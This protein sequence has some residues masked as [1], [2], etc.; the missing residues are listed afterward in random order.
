MIGP[1]L[2][3]E[4][5][6]GGRKRRLHLLRWLCGGVLWLQPMRDAAGTVAERVRQ[7]VGLSRSL[8]EAKIF[9]P[10]LVHLVASGE[11]SGRLPSMAD[12]TTV[13][14]ATRSLRSFNLPLV[15]RETSSR[16]SMRRTIWAN[17]RSI[18]AWACSVVLRS[19]PAIRKSCSALRIGARGF[20]SS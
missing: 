7:G 14:R 5:L 13:A 3:Q 10:L 17:C 1:V 2:Y 20:L 19:S 15:I 12:C 6:L 4:L 16:S 11:A 18:I 9:P 8:D